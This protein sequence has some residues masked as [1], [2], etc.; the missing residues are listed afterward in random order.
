[1]LT[2]CVLA[3]CALSIIAPY[4]ADDFNISK[5]AQTLNS[6]HS[7]AIAVFT[8]DESDGVAYLQVYREASDVASANGAHRGWVE[9]WQEG[10]RLMVNSSDDEIV[11]NTGTS[12]TYLWASVYDSAGEW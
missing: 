6:A 1:M 11:I 4:D 12:D 2:R 10:H 9:V 7:S 3:L 5:N 8:L